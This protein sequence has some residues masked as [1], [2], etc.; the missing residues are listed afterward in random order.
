MTA[1]MGYARSTVNVPPPPVRP[2]GVLSAA[3][4]IDVADGDHALLGAEYLTDA[5]AEAKLW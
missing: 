5:C 2:G 3:N 1:M 4:V